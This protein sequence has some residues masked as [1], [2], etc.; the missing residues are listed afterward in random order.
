[1]TI[2]EYISAIGIDLYPQTEA[3][4]RAI[5]EQPRSEI[6]LSGP[7]P[8]SKTTI[9]CISMS[10]LIH[11]LICSPSTLQG[12]IVIQGP[13]LSY[14][15]RFRKSILDTFSLINFK[16]S[17]SE[18]PI[19]LSKTLSIR[20]ASGRTNLLGINIAACFTS[21]DPAVE[22]LAK[23]GIVIYDTLEARDA[24]FIS[25]KKEESLSNPLI[26]VYEGRGR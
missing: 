7:S 16:Y 3:A 25:A 12:D 6:I 11:N 10:I 4:L 14:A 19:V 24:T 18:D 1:M 9:G 17:E 2:N 5:W 22:V 15:K 21:E 23:N 26:Y 13:T 8:S 20:L